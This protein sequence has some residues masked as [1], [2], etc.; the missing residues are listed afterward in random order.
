MVWDPL[1][2]RTTSDLPMQFSPH[3][4]LLPSLSA[5]VLLTSAPHRDR[6]APLSS[7][8]RGAFTSLHH[9]HIGDQKLFL[10]AHTQLKEYLDFRRSG[11]W[12]WDLS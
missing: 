9:L 4:S 6:S 1:N 5:P 8:Y 10:P 2:E 11:P 3:P 7:K 12:I